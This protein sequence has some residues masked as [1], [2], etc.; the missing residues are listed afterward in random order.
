MLETEMNEHLVYEK[1]Y[2]SVNLDDAEYT[3]EEFRAKLDK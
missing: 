2:N 3:K 1:I